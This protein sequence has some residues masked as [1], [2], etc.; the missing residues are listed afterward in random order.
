MTSKITPENKPGTSDPQKV[1]HY[2]MSMLEAEYAGPKILSNVDMSTFAGKQMVM[3]LQAG[4][5]NKLADMDG[6]VFRLQR[7]V[8]EKTEYANQSTGEMRDGLMIALID[9]DD[10]VIRCGSEG[11]GRSL[12]K[13]RDLFGDMVYTDPLFVQINK[14]T[15]GGRRVTFVLTLVDPAKVRDSQKTW[16]ADGVNPMDKK[17]NGSKTI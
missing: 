4:S 9:P 8:A 10:Q 7:W 3:A 2:V 13:L 6:K 14:I 17:P 15:T 1:V 12:D 16:I 11:L 5:E